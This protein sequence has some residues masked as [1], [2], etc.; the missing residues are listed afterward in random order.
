MRIFR[1]CGQRLS[2]RRAG[3]LVTWIGL[4]GGALAHAAVS[5]AAEC[6]PGTVYDAAT[7]TCVGAPSPVP[8]AQWDAP[9]PPVPPPL[10]PLSICPPIPFVAVC[11]PVS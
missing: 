11:I 8:A 2:T 10:P 9:A 6:G 4:C 5:N 1:P 3:L 7:D